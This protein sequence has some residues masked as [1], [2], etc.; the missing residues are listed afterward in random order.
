MVIGMIKYNEDGDVVEI[1]EGCEACE[2]YIYDGAEHEISLR[3]NLEA[4]VA[5]WAKVYKDEGEYEEITTSVRNVRRSPYSE[6]KLTGIIEYMYDDMWYT[7][8]WT[9]K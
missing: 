4:C 8:Y 9:E 6:T 2:S 5:N 1:W 3:D 7:E